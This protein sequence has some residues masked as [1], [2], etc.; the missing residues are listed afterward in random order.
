MTDEFEKAQE[1][2][3]KTRAAE[4]IQRQARAAGEF[5]R[6]VSEGNAAERLAIET[7]KASD[8]Q[9]LWDTGS[10]IEQANRFSK[11]A[12]RAA[13]VSSEALDSAA[14]L[15]SPFALGMP[16]LD[17]PFSQTRDMLMAQHNAVAE[18]QE[19]VTARRA[20]RQLLEEIREF[21]AQLDSAV[22]VG[23]WLAQFAAVGVVHI[24]AVSYRQP[25]MIVFLGE[26]EDGHQVRLVQH[27][28]QLNCLLVAAKRASPE[29]PK[30]PIGFPVDS[31]PEIEQVDMPSKG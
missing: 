8:A 10:A 30:E 3:R 12:Q 17:S 19:S 31:E 29:T 9:R 18:Q 1:V 13:V 20:V 23:A 27:L 11:E 26:L 5:A 25:H 22:E 21:D 16:R 28:S 24:R 15:L 14:K 2:M 7:R 4:E 6:R